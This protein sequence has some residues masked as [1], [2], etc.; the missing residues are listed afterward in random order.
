MGLLFVLAALNRLAIGYK[1]CWFI[2][3]LFF[4]VFL[5]LCWFSL[6]LIGLLGFWFDVNLV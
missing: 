1:C 2:M 4:Y 5:F 3:M 6:L